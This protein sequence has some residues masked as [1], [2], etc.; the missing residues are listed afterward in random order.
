[1]KF[2]DEIE[3]DT[4]QDHDLVDV[5]VRLALDMGRSEA[6]AALLTSSLYSQIEQ[7]KGDK[8][9]KL[10]SPIPTKLEGVFQLN[11]DESFGLEESETPFSPGMLDSNEFEPSKSSNSSFINIFQLQKRIKPTQFVKRSWKS[12]NL[13]KRSTPRGR[14]VQKP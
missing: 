6:E 4:T 14:Q 2:Q 5:G 13:L 9:D 12:S 11:S 8:T 7:D 1:V 10:P 3:N